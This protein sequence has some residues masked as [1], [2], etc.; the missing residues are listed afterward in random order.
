ML[1][2]MAVWDTPENQ[3]HECTRKA[4]FSLREQVDTAKH[5][6]Y[7]IDNGSTCP[8]TL[9]LIDALVNGGLGM[10]A[11]IF[12]NNKNVGTARAINQAWKEKLLGEHCVKMDNDVVV[13]Q[14]NWPD[15]M[16]EVFRRDPSIGICGLKR[17]DVEESPLNS[18]PFYH[19]ELQMLP[20]E[21]GQRWVVV[22]NVN[23]VIG[24]CQG[25]SSSLLDKIGYLC[26]MG[27]LYG[28]DDAL[29]SARCRLAGFRSVFLP[30][31][32]IDHVDNCEPQY[33]RWK[34]E[35]AGQMMAEYNELLDD[36]KSGRRSLYQGLK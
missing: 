28:F 34:Q 13:S 20:H 7:I 29:A 26:Q 33:Q 17:K 36:Y 8:K 22:E 19:S 4:L 12:V 30:A 11:T 24:T 15:L 5:R 16:E 25:Y 21:R 6:I 23:H 2:A 31:V 27:G 32:D 1:I 18:H 35:Y 9:N 14:P 10:K 3:R